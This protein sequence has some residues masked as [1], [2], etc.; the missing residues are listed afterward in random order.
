MNKAEHEGKLHA[1]MEKNDE[2]HHSAKGGLIGAAVGRA[3]THAHPKYHAAGMA[4][5]A[6]LGADSGA[7]IGRLRGKERTLR[8]TVTQE[9]REARMKKAALEGFEDRIKK[10]DA[11][12]TIGQHVMGAGMRAAKAVG[13]QGRAL[14]LV[15]KGTAA[16]GGKGIAGRLELAKRVGQGT[17]ALGAGAAGAAAYEATKR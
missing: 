7:R 4:A 12:T 6:L 15:N 1:V 11:F 8:D 3:L 17:A 13:Q 14:D 16:L 9:R 5:G 10:A 2:I